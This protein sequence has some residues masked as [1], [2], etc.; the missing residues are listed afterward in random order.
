MK[1]FKMKITITLTNTD[2]QSECGWASDYSV[3]TDDEMEARDM[4]YSLVST[5]VDEA[6]KYFDCSVARVFKEESD[7]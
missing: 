5:G 1:H 3:Y 2:D 4:C 6:T 7:E